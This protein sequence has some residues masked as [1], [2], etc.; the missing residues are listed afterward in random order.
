MRTYARVTMLAACASIAI[1]A[2][3]Q[4]KQLPVIH[5]SGSG[6]AQAF[7][8]YDTRVGEQI[9]KVHGSGSSGWPENPLIF[10]NNQRLVR[11]KQG[12]DAPV[13][14]G[15]FTDPRAFRESFFPGIV[16]DQWQP[17]DCTLAVGPEY[18][19]AT[20]NM[21][22][23]FYRKSDGANV[24][25][26]WLGNQENQGFFRGVGALGFTFD[27]KCL[28]DRNSGR[29]IVI[30]PEFYT[31]PNRAALCVAVS[32]DSDPNGV[33]YLYRSDFKQI[34]GGVEYWVDYP[35]LGV[36]QEAIFVNGNLF[37][38]NSGFGG[39]VYRV[40]PLAP[41]LSGGAMTFTDLRDGNSGSV[42]GGPH[43]GSSNA[44]F[45]VEDWST[46]SMRLHAIQNA[47]GSPT[48]HAIDVSVPSFAYPNSS[49]PQLG[50]SSID[51]LDGRVMNA[52]WK[53][54]RFVASHA[55]R[56]GSSGNRTIG[57]WYEFNTGNWPQSG[58][59][60]LIQSGN[61]DPGNNAYGLFPCVGYNDFKDI[62]MILGRS[63]SSQY[64]G[65]YVTGRK[66]TDA[67]GFMGAVTEVKIGSATWTGGRWGDYF[68]VQTD[69]NDGLT[70]WGVGEYCE[71]GAWRTWIDSWK[72]AQY[73][74][75]TVRAIQGVVGPVPA[76]ISITTDGR[77][78]G[79][80]NAP[81]VR[82]YYS[83]SNITVSAPATF[84]GKPFRAWI[85][86]P[87][88]PGPSTPTINLTLGSDRTIT[89]FYDQ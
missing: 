83:G 49:A 81:I 2:I 44:A 76:P 5:P 27:P 35:G 7:E 48:L 57:R 41:L 65:V 45:F 16:Q 11:T 72:V 17:P 39:V 21:K 38:F 23:G 36:T 3:A 15:V 46:T 58:G 25:L 19:V 54:Q 47:L 55:V 60:S 4:G 37:G 9:S 63:A 87:G 31:G 12:V 26:R 69:P 56:T 73:A 52:Q 50:G 66:F 80:G 89:A 62:G 13:A 33:W 70:F 75:L 61:V 88:L 42:Q 86:G 74:N 28:Y 34:I 53:S 67:A 64:A 32:D 10:K 22:I 84:N 30:C 24:F 79:N 14:G 51:V 43:V 59:V 82:T 77:G 6:E 85:F 29:F 20:T 8:I 40:I 1:G 18:V 71:A 78:D 68:A